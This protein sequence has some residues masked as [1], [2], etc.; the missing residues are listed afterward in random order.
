VVIGSNR[1][2]AVEYHRNGRA[3]HSPDESDQANVARFNP[4][5][6]RDSFWT[7]AR[8]CGAD[9]ADVQQLLGHTSSKTTARYADVVPEKLFTATQRMEEAWVLNTRG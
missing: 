8:R 5:K 6:L 9:M 7:L 3:W 1:I 2:H 4:Y